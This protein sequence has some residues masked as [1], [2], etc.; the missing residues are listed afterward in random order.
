MTDLTDAIE[1]GWATADAD[2]PE[3]AVSYFRDL[4]AQH[5][6]D[7]HALLAYA[8]ALDFAGR[9]A[10]AVPAYEQAFAAGL[11]G[12]DL[13]QGL[14]QY[15]STLRNL[16]RFDDA[17][18]AL[19][20]ADDQFPGHASV[21]VFLALALS[22]GG[23]RHQAV[24]ILITLALDRINSDELQ[25]YQRPLRSYAADLTRHMPDP[26]QGVTMNKVTG[27][28][29][30]NAE[31]EQRSAD[32]WASLDSRSEEDFL[33]RIEELAAEL[34]QDHPVALF[35]RACAL[36]STGHPDLAVPLYRQAL[37][38]GLTGLRRRR[39]VVQM[40]SSLR[41]IGRAQESV[42]LLTAERNVDPATLDEPT[43]AL[44]DGVMATLALAL[45]D[46]GREREA[47]SVALTAL[48]PHL[49][50]YQRSMANY[51]RLLMEPE[52]QE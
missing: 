44:A 40:A 37:D 39:A 21:N 12:D 14:I 50:R 42:A 25:Q 9:E 5:P 23:R 52:S 45:A 10:E 13:R 15:G 38:I 24:Q 35:E 3:P 47:V 34:P 29:D 6:C 26:T 22:S 28:V 46:T 19:R 16:G 33:A 32:L 30:V 49:V 2:A 51:A 43:R 36:D 48:A 1:R 8:S 31:W 20:Q 27:Q 4:L 17:V 7:R 18:T 41:N 11:D